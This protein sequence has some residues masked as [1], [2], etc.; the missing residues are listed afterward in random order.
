MV[1]VGVVILPKEPERLTAERRASREH[2]HLPHDH[3]VNLF[4]ARGLEDN[5]PAL[6]KAYALTELIPGVWS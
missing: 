1:D 6:N 3:Y 2:P 5:T 4:V